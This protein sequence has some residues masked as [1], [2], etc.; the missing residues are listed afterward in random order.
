MPPQTVAQ[1]EEF[2][3][4]NAINDLNN[5]KFLTTAEAARVHKVDYQKLWARQL[6]WAP[7]LTVGGLNKTLSPDQEAALCL[8]MNRC[9]ALGRP[10]KKKHIQAAA[11][12]ILRAASKQIQVSQ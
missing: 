7:K 10:A 12:T 1:A 5:G 9:I 2:R 8:Y 3:I 6:G 11:N 4:A